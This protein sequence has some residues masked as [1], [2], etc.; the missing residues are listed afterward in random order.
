M[1]NQELLKAHLRLETWPNHSL[2]FILFWFYGHIPAADKEKLN[3]STQEQN[4]GT[5]AE[6]HTWT[7]QHIAI[8]EL[9]IILSKGQTLDFHVEQMLRPYRCSN[10]RSYPGGQKALESAVLNDMVLVLWHLTDRS[11]SRPVIEQAC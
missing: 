5:C 7:D 6:L 11:V 10:L 4:P 1:L 9:N 2:D 3:I 8:Q